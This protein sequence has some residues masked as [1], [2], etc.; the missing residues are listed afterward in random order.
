MSES[1]GHLQLGYV[2]MHYSEQCPLLCGLRALQR[3]IAHENGT[4]VLQCYIP[5][6]P[7]DHSTVL[8]LIMVHFCTALS[9]GFVA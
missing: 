3:R 4:D 7:C 5:Y 9:L 2:A 6:I 1:V 8:S